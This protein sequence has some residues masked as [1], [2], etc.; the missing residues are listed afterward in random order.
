MRLQPLAV[1]QIDCVPGDVI[2]RRAALGTGQ[3]RSLVVDLGWRRG[4]LRSRRRGRRHGHGDLWRGLL[5]RRQRDCRPYGPGPRQRHGDD[6][7]H[8]WLWR[9]H[10][11]GCRNRRGRRR[12][13]RHWRQNRGLGDFMFYFRMRMRQRDRR[14]SHP[15]LRRRNR[16]CRQPH[17]SRPRPRSVPIS[18]RNWLAGRRRDRPSAS[19]AGPAGVRAWRWGLPD[20]RHAHHPDAG[21]GGDGDGRADSGHGRNAHG[22][23]AKHAAQQ[24]ARHSP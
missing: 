4:L 2:K 3:R 18:P 6:V 13:L 7:R 16:M 11:R 17:R 12:Q 1:R 21:N 14:R 15:L 20:S 8:G 22:R 23:A 19:R 10:V 5:G 24:P 9:R